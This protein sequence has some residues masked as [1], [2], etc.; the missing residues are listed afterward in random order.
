LPGGHVRYWHIADI[1]PRIIYW[2]MFLTPVLSG[3]SFGP[4]PLPAPDESGLSF[5]PL[6]VPPPALGLLFGLAVPPPALGLLFGLAVPPP[7]LG[8]W[9]MF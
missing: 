5:G 7:G 2:L 9:L 8:F 6:A 3:V 4:F 1:T